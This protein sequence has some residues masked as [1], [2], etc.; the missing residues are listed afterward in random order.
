[1]ESSYYIPSIEEFHIGFEYLEFNEITQGYEKY[2]FEEFKIMRQVD[3]TRIYS[4]ETIEEYLKRAELEAIGELEYKRNSILPKS[5]LLHLYKVKYLDV[6]DVKNLGWVITKE[7]DFEFDA[8]YLKEDDDVFWELTYDTDE[9]SLLIE[10]FYQA[11]MCAAMPYSTHPDLYSSRVIFDG[12]INN[13]SEL[14]K[15]MQI[16]HINER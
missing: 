9:K 16:L 14:K 3:F 8:Q 1:M 2:I 12:F 10:E 15:L 7:G 11:K 6:E 13:K 5:S 4:Y